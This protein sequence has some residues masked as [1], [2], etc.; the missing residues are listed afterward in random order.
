MTL[1]AALAAFL[2]VFVFSFICTAFGLRLLR[3]V[4]LDLK[5]D[6]EQVLCSTA[7]GFIAFEVLLALAE[8]AVPLR[9]SVVAIFA[10]VAVLS[11]TEW[12]TLLQVSSGIL[13][14]IAR[15]TRVEP[16]LVAFVGIVL[17]L[18]GLAAMAPMTGSDALHYHFT[19]PLHILRNGFYP[20]FFLT[21]SFLTGQGH[22]LILTGLALGSEK[23][24]MGLLFLP[25]ALAAVCAARLA[26][27]WVSRCWA[28]LV[29]LTFLLNPVVFWQ[30]STAGVPDLWMAF[31]ATTGVLLIARARSDS[32]TAL[33][34][35]CGVLAGGVAGTKYLG[36]VFAAA[37]LLAFLWESRSLKRTGLFLAGA[38]VAGIWPYVR[39][40]L[41]TGDPVF[42][43]AMSWLAPSTVNSRAVASLVAST[44]VSSQRTLGA[45]WRFPLFAVVNRSNLG[46]WE[47]FGPLCLMFLPL[48]LLKAGRT[49]HWRAALIVTIAGSLGVGFTSGMGRYT[50]PVLPVALAAAIAG[51][52][53]VT[54]EPWKIARGIVAASISGFL[55]LDA[56]AFA[57]YSAPALRAAV[58]LTAREDY[59]MQRSPDFALSEFVNQSLA[60][61]ESEGTTLV[62][63]RHLYYLRV[64]YLYGD[65]QDSWA[66]DPERLTTSQAWR[67]FFRWYHI[68]WVVRA[69]DYPEE[70]AAPLEQLERDGTL[71]LLASKD[72]SIFQGMRIRR[73]RQTVRT[74]IFRVSD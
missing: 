14:H 13:Q 34:T 8:F 16:L 69:P 44:V 66:V 11:V 21:T 18:E 27:T 67:E 59:L 23:L 42:P 47:F 17:L 52:A 58:G 4:R 10:A 51:A 61:K 3:A 41:W 53:A 68:R 39:N 22:L 37:L 1:I 54:A 24:A 35:C 62:F 70:I 46:F 38:L 19:S 71:V 7:V 65:P 43:F 6:T 5:N 32:T 55:I 36:C 9:L 45:A 2:G 63:F 31:F 25:G 40:L 28:I 60:G 30:I 72:V 49:A 12:R 50:L 26:R 15:G 73:I 74:T 57:V 56:G 29:G 64:P 33:A 20:D 48:F